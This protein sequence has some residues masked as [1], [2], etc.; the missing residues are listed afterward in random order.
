MATLQTRTVLK[1]IEIHFDET[2]GQ[3]TTFVH[4]LKQ[5]LNDDGKVVLSQPHRTPMPDADDLA[6]LQMVE[7][8]DHLVELGF[9]PIPA[10]D[11][12]LVDKHH[13][14]SRSDFVQSPKGIEFEKARVSA[15]AVAAAREAEAARD[16]EKTAL[17][18]AE[19]ETAADAIA[20][21]IA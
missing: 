19:A 9:D 14:A 3:P 10:D 1:R 8:N 21:P 18:T 4:I 13:R 12:A 6:G 11:I 20:E 15:A 7:V 16:A 17:A 5:G 2:T